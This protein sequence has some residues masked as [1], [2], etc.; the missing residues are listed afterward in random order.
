[1]VWAEPAREA[2]RFAPLTFD[3]FWSVLY[4]TANAAAWLGQAD[5]EP[6]TSSC[7]EAA[8]DLTEAVEELEWVDPTVAGNGA[9]DVGPVTPLD[10]YEDCLA[11]TAELIRDAVGFAAAMLGESD[12]RWEHAQLTAIARAVFLLARAYTRLTGTAM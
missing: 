10:R 12:T 5:P 2:A 6:W 8:L 7:P 1:M 9:I 11:Q 4:A 3:G